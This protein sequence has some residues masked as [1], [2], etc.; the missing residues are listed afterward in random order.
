MNAGMGMGMGMKT[1]SISPLGGLEESPR[2][3]RW[4]CFRPVD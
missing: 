1:V 4:C 3:D 2:C